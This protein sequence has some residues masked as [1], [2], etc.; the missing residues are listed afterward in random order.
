MLPVR[1]DARQAV[2]PVLVLLLRWG[3]QVMLDAAMQLASIGPVM[4]V[5]GKRPI[6]PD[7]P[8]R[9]TRTPEGADWQTATG[10]GLLTGE[11]AGYFV[12]DVDGAVG[13]ETLAMLERENSTLP[14]TWT[15]HTGGGGAHLFF[16]HP[17]FPV[18][19]SASKIGRGLD[20]RG[21]G[22]QVVAPPSAHP[23][24]AKYEWACAPWDTDLANA[25]EWLLAMLRPVLRPV[26]APLPRTTDTLRRAGAYLA[27]IPGAVA[28]ARGHDTA[29][30]A[31]LAVVRGFGLSES[32]SFNL[33]ASDY[34]PRCSPPWSDKELEHKIHSAAQD[35]RTTIGYLRDRPLD[36]QPRVSMVHAEPPPQV[37]DAADRPSRFMLEKVADLLKEEIPPTKW[38]LAPY[39]PAAS[40]GELVGPPG[41]GK[42]TFMAWMIMQ[43]AMAGHRCV[44][45]EEEGSRKGLQR[46]LGRALA[47]V[48]GDVGER[49]QFMHAQGVNLLNPSD[50]RDL[51]L[52]LKGFDFVLMDSFNLVTPGLDE[53]KSKDMGSV[54]KDIRFLRSEL[55][56]AVWLN[57]HSGKSK[58]KPGEVP[59]LGDGRGSSALPGALDSELSMKPVEVPEQGFIQF[60][61]YVTKMREGDD[62]IPPKRV[63]IARNGPAAILEMSEQTASAPQADAHLALAILEYLTAAG[64][65]SKNKIEQNVKGD[66]NAI[67]AAL[68]ALKYSSRVEEIPAGSYSKWGVR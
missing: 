38:L 27:K 66:T 14:R 10:V 42:T 46:L 57:H 34:N 54:I 9:A 3:R 51:H 31:A 43:M 20:V 16:R 52:T 8:N 41:K 12:L 44:I 18:R 59:K 35:G 29:W 21:E 64:P 23:S 5:N 55:Q 45:I 33:L 63:S 53:D 11:K 30:A 60:E 61:L 40:F 39:V 48:G 24:G 68:Q 58:W 15:S 37:A 4:P 22:G 56:I 7:W 1:E 50:V 17:G 19:G 2:P 36:A 6:W 47:A 26:P 28:G 65:C 13:A 62:Q 67:R 49:V 25:P 32:E